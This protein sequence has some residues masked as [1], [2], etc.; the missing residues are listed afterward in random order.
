[1]EKRTEA[2]STQAQKEPDTRLSAAA[3][4]CVNGYAYALGATGILRLPRDIAGA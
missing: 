4:T 3:K 1:L 2:H